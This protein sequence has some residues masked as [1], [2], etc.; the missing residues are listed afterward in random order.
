MENWDRVYERPTTTASAP[1][2]TTHDMATT[3]HGTAIAAGTS[4]S[5]STGNALVMGAITDSP[6]HGELFAVFSGKDSI[7]GTWT[8]A[9]AT[10][11]DC[12]A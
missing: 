3:K 8:T 10:G 12:N 5:D 4:N 1:I 7:C 2:A 11:P 6:L 9:T